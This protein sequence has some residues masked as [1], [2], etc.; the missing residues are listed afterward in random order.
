MKKILLLITMLALM[1][2]ASVDAQEDGRQRT[3]ATV[4]A[5]ALAQLPAQTPDVYNSVMAELAATGSEGVEMIADMLQVVKEGVNNSPMEYALSGVAT[6]VTKADDELRAGVREGLKAAF[7]KEEAPV[8][9]AYLMQTLE[10]CATAEDA[11]FYVAQLA[12]DYLDE[13]E[14]TPSA[15]SCSTGAARASFPDRKSVV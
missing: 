2:F 6:Y 14:A 8:L 1:P 4:V 11:E 7:A 3:M 9:K 15:M 13:Y 10:I 5:D 12:D